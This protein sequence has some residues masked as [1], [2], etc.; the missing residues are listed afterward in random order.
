MGFGNRERDRAQALVQPLDHL[1]RD[2]HAFVMQ[3][4]LLLMQHQT[5]TGFGRPGYLRLS[6]TVPMDTIER[7]LPAFAR[8]RRA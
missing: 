1:G 8:A 7:S 4:N 5:G 3:E 2:V 6:F